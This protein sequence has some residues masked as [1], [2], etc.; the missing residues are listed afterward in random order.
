MEEKQDKESIM[1]V[2][3]IGYIKKGLSYKFINRIE[4]PAVDFHPLGIQKAPTRFLVKVNGYNVA[5]CLW[6]SPK[7]TRSYP[8]ARVYDILTQE[9]SKKVSI[10]PIVK[11][12]GIEEIETWR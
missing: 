8:Y 10:I 6:V 1:T 9:A 5:V 7:R 3:F 11:D 12:E 4:I 2:E